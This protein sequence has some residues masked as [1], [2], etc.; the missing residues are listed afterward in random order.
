[1]K[2]SVYKALTKPKRIRAQIRKAE[3]EMEGLKLSM[4]PGAIRYDKDKVQLSP[5][6]PM[7]KYVVRLDELERKIASLQMDYLDAQGIP[8]AITSSSPIPRIQK[9]LAR[10]G[11]D[12]RFAALCSGR[13]VPNGKPEPDIYLKACGALGVEPA[14]ALALEDSRKLTLS[15]ISSHRWLHFNNCTWP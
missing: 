14:E 15:T 8:A 2:E 10:H 1:M 7:A 13:D 12:T 9:Y 6:D 4:L 3:A 11:L 5:E